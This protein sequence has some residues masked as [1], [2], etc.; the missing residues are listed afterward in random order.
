MLADLLHGP[1]APDVAERGFQAAAM[2]DRGWVGEALLG[3]RGGRLQRPTA[4]V[5]RQVENVV[6]RQSEW[7]R[8]S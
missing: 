1:R 8:L 2:Q 4:G 6:R 5:G 3:Q 7:K